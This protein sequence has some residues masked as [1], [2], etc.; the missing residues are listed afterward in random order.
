MHSLVDA[1]FEVTG[2]RE[3]CATADRLEGGKEVEDLVGQ[4]F[5]SGGAV[6][7]IEN[8][9]CDSCGRSVG[10]WGGNELE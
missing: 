6:E 4:F 3:E 5:V 7:D 1:G 2:S 9:A 8:G 10:P